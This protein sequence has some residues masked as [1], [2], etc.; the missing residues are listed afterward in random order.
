MLYLVSIPGR[1]KRIQQN[2]ESADEAVKII[3]D[4]LTDELRNGAVIEDGFAE[5]SADPMSQFKR[6]QDDGL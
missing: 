5:E 1:N 3:F 4:N 6:S 2:A